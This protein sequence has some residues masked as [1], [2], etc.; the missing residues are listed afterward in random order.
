MS[1]YD[2]IGTDYSRTEIRSVRRLEEPRGEFFPM[3][4]LPLLGIFALSVFSCAGIQETTESF[5]EKKLAANNLDWVEASAS[6][7]TVTLNGAVPNAAAEKKA[8][9]LSNEVQESD[10]MG[11]PFPAIDV[12]RNF[13][14]PEGERD[15]DKE[16]IAPIAEGPELTKDADWNFTLANK[17]LTLNGEVPNEATRLDVIQAAQR[18]VQAPS[19]SAVSDNLIVLNSE[20]PEG[21]SDVASQGIRAISYC[22][23]GIVSFRSKVLDLNCELP[24]RLESVARQE[25]TSSIAYGRLG[26]IALTATEDID[27]CEG[28]LS[29]L[30][31]ETQI[32]FATGSS[33]IDAASQS[34]IT[35]I[36]EEAQGC[37]GTLRI[38][39]HTD[40]TG[41][42]EKNEELSA[43]RAEAVRAALV[44]NGV[45]ANRL[46]S[47]GFGS[48]QPAASNATADGRAR[49]RRIE[50][51]VVGP[52]E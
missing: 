36:S 23:E 10:W 34:L 46:V 35:K 21:Y 7:R 8:T 37:P 44:S 12:V 4:F 15:Q 20:A 26:D 17:V 29:T 3:G 32:R 25:I 27:A 49:N 47:R 2:D 31:S 6:G 16:V 24:R 48:R 51:K 52:N 14:I 28:S 40:S 33:E 41:S 43:Q 45:D 11:V 18:A 5:V 13:T 38:E 1:R 50:I 39:G 22:D 9:R 19:I 30:L 42:N